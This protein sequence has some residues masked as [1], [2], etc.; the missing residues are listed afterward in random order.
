MLAID[1]RRKIMS[2]LQ[3]N[4]S[5]MVPELSKLFTVTEE[6]I[7]RDLESLEKEGLL[8]RTHGGA[9]L[10]ESINVEMPLNIRE[11]TNIEGKQAIG[12]KVADFI[13]DG[14]TIMLDSSSTALQVAKQ[15]KTKKKITVITNSVK[16]A[17][18]LSNAKDCTVISTG[19]MLKSSSLCYI[20][21]LAEKSIANY[22]VDKAVISCKGLDRDK[23]I[24]DSN[25][26]EG[27]IK[28]KMVHAAAKVY[29]A[30]DHAKF[31]KVSF[32]QLLNFSDIDVVFTDH[33]LSPEWER[34]FNSQG[35]QLIYSENEK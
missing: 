4:H 20:G 11:V 17:L 6:T 16:V 25:E 35:V 19:G 24:T 7:R 3:A 21:H 5:V 1:R 2:L 29:L 30:A 33:P 9:V 28:K 13:E 22:N 14:D 27:E 10:N 34:H 23:G 8:K 18:E 15:I 32:F 26:M 12:L 31:N